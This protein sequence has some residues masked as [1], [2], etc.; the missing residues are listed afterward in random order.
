MT[1][2]SR[3][4]VAA[5]TAFALVVLAG[6][7]VTHAALSDLVTHNGFEA[8]W[9]QAITQTQFLALQQAT[10]EGAVACVPQSGGSITGGTYS[11][12]NMPACPGGVTGCPI[13]LHSGAFSGN[14]S[15]GTTMFSAAGSA[16]DIVIDI[17][18]TVFSVPGTCTITF[19]NV[20]LGYSLYYTLQPD[21]NSGLYAV[22]LDQAIMLVDD[23]YGTV[24]GGVCAD[25]AQVYASSIVPQAES[26]G[27]DLIATL[28]E[29]ATVG[30][31]VCPLT[32]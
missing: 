19:N 8:C 20:N 5:R 26:L 10:I 14:F 17:S 16:D 27:S 11:A 7:E 24:G 4:L 32:P 29:P 18:Y 21:G 25:L 23:G 28:E 15:S 22:S 2:L 9:S 6:A 31:A 30:E 3:C 13:T 12:C 1:S